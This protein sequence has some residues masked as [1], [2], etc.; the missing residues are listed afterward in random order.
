MASASLA[1]GL[2]VATSVPS[3]A[4]TTVA[5]TT[6]TYN[7]TLWD[8]FNRQCITG[9]LPG[10]DLT[11]IDPCGGVLAYDQKFNVVFYP[12]Y[13]VIKWSANPNYCLDGRLGKGNVML[14]PCGSDGTHEDWIFRS[15]GPDLIRIE[16]LFNT[17]CLDAR[18][19][20]GNLTLQTCGND[21]THEVFFWA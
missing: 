18:E 15:D 20:T 7:V 16:D 12:G 2:T 4:A 9:I 19:G 13:N 10:P 14:Q 1:A 17:E 8:L 3:Q 5:A 6:T 21:S 11:E